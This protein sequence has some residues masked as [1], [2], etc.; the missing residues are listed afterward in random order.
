M[1]CAAD[2]ERITDA[3]RELIETYWPKRKTPVDGRIDAA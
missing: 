1:D 3:V 2:G